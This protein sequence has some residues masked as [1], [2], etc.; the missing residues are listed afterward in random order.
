[1]SDTHLPPPAPEPDLKAQWASLQP[2]QF[3]L[4]R[5]APLP[6]EKG[7]GA[8]HLRFARLGRVERHHPQQS[9]LRMSI[10]LPGQVLHKEHNRLELWADHRSRELRLGIDGG[11]QIEP[12]NRG[13]GRLLLAQ[14][15]I[16]AKQR[17]GSY[18][19]VG[20]A[21]PAK[22]SL[23]DNSRGRRDRVMKALG[24]KLTFE[25]NLQLKGQYSAGKVSEL[26]SDWNL[27]KAQIIDLLIELQ[28]EMGLAMIFIS[29]DL[30]VVREISHRVMVLYLGRVMELADRDRLYAGLMLQQADQS[31]HEQALKIRQAEDRVAAFKRNESSLRFSVN[32]LLGLCGFLTLLLLFLVFV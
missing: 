9:M 27:E 5:L 6:I 28:K 18:Q 19:V 13:L 23:D 14:G 29:H 3:Q 2:N 21:L 8:R 4:L 26:S 16:W 12:A 22:G 31:L 15:V 20:G 11:L 17:W 1:M 10:E 7:S 30:A 32:A 25:D 24:V